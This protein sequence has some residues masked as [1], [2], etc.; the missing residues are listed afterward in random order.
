MH[1][2]KGFKQKEH[3]PA[4]PD[5]ASKSQLL[6]FPA[7]VIFLLRAWEVRF[8]IVILLTLLFMPSVLIWD[9]L[10]KIEKEEEKDTLTLI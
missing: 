4:V 8:Q 1:A 2:Q 3:L 9:L 5:R 7:V 6:P 10:R